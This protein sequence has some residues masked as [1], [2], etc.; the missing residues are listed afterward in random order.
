MADDR[1]LPFPQRAYKHYEE[2][3]NYLSVVTEA[4][5][6][7]EREEVGDYREPLSLDTRKEVTVL[8]SWGGPSDGYKIYF[9]EDGDPQEGFYFF[10]DWFEH[11]E[12]KLPDEQLDQVIALYF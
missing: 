9:D 10:A 2:A 4:L 6:E 12:F 5:Q 7:H 8:L 1:T 3:K 11:E